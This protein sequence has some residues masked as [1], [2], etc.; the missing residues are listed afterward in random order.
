M[1]LEMLKLKSI[2]C[3]YVCMFEFATRNLKWLKKKVNIKNR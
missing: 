3:V 1:A 2:V